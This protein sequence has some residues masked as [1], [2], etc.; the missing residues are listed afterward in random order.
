VMNMLK[1][2]ESL[3]KISRL[4]GLS[5]DDVVKIKERR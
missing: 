2:N 5:L 3:D 1:E 4:T